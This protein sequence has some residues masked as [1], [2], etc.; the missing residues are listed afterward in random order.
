MTIEKLRKVYKT[1]LAKYRLDKSNKEAKKAWKAAKKA[2]RD[3][4]EQAAKKRSLPDVEETSKKKLKVG[5]S[6]DE[7]K[8][9]KKKAKAA[10]KASDNDLKLKGKYKKALAALNEAKAQK[11]NAEEPKNEEP[12][13]EEPEVDIAA[14]KAAVKEA[15][16]AYRAEKSN[17]E[18][19]KKF[20]K[21]KKALAVAETV[22]ADKKKP[23]ATPMVKK[24]KPTSIN[25]PAKTLWVGNLNYKVDDDAVKEFF[26]DCGEITKIRWLTHAD[27]GN[28]KGCGFL[29]FE[30]QEEA[31]KAF[32]KRDE[33]FMG[34]K[35]NTEYAKPLNQRGP[36]E[37]APPSKRLFLG[38][39]SYYAD[40][41]KLREHFKE[42]GNIK[43]ITWCTDKDTDEFK[44]FGFC[45]FWDQESADKAKALSGQDFCGCPLVID[46]TFPRNVNN[47]LK[48]PIQ[49]PAGCTSVFV[50]GIPDNI[51]D[52]K[53]KTFFS[54]VGTIS[55]INWLK[56]FTTGKFRGAGWLTFSDPAVL[57]YAVK[58]NGM[59][60]EGKNIRV[61]YAKPRRR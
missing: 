1:A 38:N 39:V 24:W 4:E 34:Q 30:T 48:R 10:W 46:Y 3:A 15:R 28:F 36:K 58:K 20:K 19:K 21:A 56:N 42:C 18:A 40:D 60:F 9:A 55:E 33:E 12:K 2:V 17:N 61:D 49:R 51:N 50:A 7:L 13:T 47:N 14:L 59:Q 32:E 8:E 41:D 53:I 23:E 22:A 25:P 44:G 31:T 37:K 26:K 54:D 43:N 35:I 27:S 29:T 5:P 16:R 57:D 45:T 52:D 11:K 6:I